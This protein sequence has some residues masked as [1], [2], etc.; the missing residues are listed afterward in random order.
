MKT[1]VVIV[2]DHASLRGMLTLI[3]SQGKTYEVVGQA[4]SGLS[5]MRVC[6]S[7]RPDLVI[8]DLM[9]PELSGTEVLRRLRIS[10]P[11]TRILVY[12][13]TCNQS[14]VIETLKHRPDGFVNKS[15]SLETLREA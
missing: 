6:R 1:R 10:M 5:A 8:L 13:G 7:L 14:L 2:D 9:L 3:L 11:A 4:D 15:D 12:S